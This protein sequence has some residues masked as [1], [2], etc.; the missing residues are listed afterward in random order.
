MARM[1]YGDEYERLVAQ[2][3]DG[4]YAVIRDPSGDSDFYRSIAQETG[5]PLLE[6]GCGTGRVLL[7]SAGTG[8][9][10]VGLDASNEM[11]D[12]LRKKNP[13][14]NVTLVQGR[15]EDFDLG[16]GRFRLI[17]A[18]FR[19]MQHLLD[20]QTQLAVIRNDRELKK[21]RLGFLCVARRPDNVPATSYCSCRMPW[22]GENCLE[23]RKS[24]VDFHPPPSAPPNKI[25]A[26][27]R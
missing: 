26:R 2:T 6:L 17:T 8:I 7:E 24:M 10:C 18:P 21:P 12:V 16:A 27:S 9:E 4:V 13:P 1:T 19:A 15:I 11:L 23:N 20:P 5:G 14:E 25:L 3:Y 22:R